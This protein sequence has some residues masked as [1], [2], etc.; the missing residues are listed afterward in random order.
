MNNENFSNCSLLFLRMKRSEIELKDAIIESQYNSTEHARMNAIDED[1]YYDRHEIDRKNYKEKCLK[2]PW[3][4][5]LKGSQTSEIQTGRIILQNLRNIENKK[6]EED[7]KIK[8]W[9]QLKRLKEKL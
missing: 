7:E 6:K 4:W 9:R 2:Y 1:W 8:E 5:I 3:D